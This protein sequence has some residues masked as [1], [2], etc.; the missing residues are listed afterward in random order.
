M[1]YR[2]IADVMWG[3]SIFS[4]CCPGKLNSMVVSS[5]TADCRPKWA[6]ERGPSLYMYISFEQQKNFILSGICSVAFYKRKQTASPLFLLYII[7]L[8][9][10]II[11]TIKAETEF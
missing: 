4:R 10:P 11:P 1:I 9:Q 3:L 5:E 8:V 2:H 6:V 7:L